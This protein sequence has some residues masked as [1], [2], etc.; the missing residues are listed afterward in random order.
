[1]LYQSHRLYELSKAIDWVSLEEEITVLINHQ[2]QAQWRLVSGAIY[3][4]SFYGLS[5]ADIIQQWSDCPKLR[6]FCTGEMLAESTSA[7]PVSSEV[8]EKLS[9]ELEGKGYHAMIKALRDFK[10]FDDEQPELSVTI[11]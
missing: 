2:Y 1:M 3:L 8:L 6:F 5:T 4:K 10:Q 9:L 7:F 11:H